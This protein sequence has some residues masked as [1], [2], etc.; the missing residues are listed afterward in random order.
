MINDR[1]L[2]RI[3][4]RVIRERDWSKKKKEHRRLEL[5]SDSLVARERVTKLAALLAPHKVAGHSKIRLGAKNDGGYICIDDF[6]VIKLAF[7]FGIATDVSWDRDIA[8]RGIVVHQFDHTVDTAPSSHVNFRFQQKKIVGIRCG[9]DEE[10]ISSLVTKH[11]LPPAASILKID[12][13]HDEWD[14]FLATP[15]HDL[16]RFSQIICEFHGFDSI[17]TKEWYERAFL[18]LERLHGDFGAVH[19]HGNNFLPWISIGNIPFPQLL[20]V[21]YANRMRYSLESTDQIFP[22]G[23][24]APN[25]PT[26]PDLHLGRF[27]F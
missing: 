19:V 16:A 21:T 20:E 14:V 18:V 11:T 26:K 24:D 15:S 6:D 12:I 5:L 9:D 4:L 8:D 25:D 13:D 27:V 10:T 17:I 1:I 3:G 2:T 7:S 23:L 22:T